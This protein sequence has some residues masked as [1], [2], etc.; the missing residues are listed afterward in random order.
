MKPGKDPAAAAAPGGTVLCRLDD[1]A[2]G[3]SSGFAVH[4]RGEL[5]RFMILRRNDHVFVYANRCPHKGLPL[6]FTPGRFLDHSKTHILCT[7]HGAVFRIEDG[8]CVS[9]PCAG[10]SL[11]RPATEV[12]NGTVYLVD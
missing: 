3:G 12:L 1:V 2:D 10:E 11:R 7:N 4:R 8:F 6:D 5:L 9:G